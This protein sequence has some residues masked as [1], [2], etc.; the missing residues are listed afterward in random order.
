M[1][2]KKDFEEIEKLRNNII[3]K[4]RNII[5]TFPENDEIKNLTKLGGGGY[6]Y[7][8]NFSQMIGSVWAPS[9]YVF[10]HQYK[11]V[12]DELEHTNTD[13]IISKLEKI[14]SDGCVGKPYG[15]TILHPKVISNLKT[16]L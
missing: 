1:G 11:A 4:V 13:N 2:L 16:L 10:E 8:I 6:M 9:Y 12:L 14:I 15:K 3:T 7:T 5:S